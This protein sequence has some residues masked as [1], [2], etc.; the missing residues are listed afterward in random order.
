MKMN[1]KFYVLLLP[2]FFFACST[3]PYQKNE[4]MTRQA[5]DGAV[6]YGSIAGGGAAG[7][8]A[9]KQIGGSTEAGIAGAVVGTGLTY[10]V[11]KFYDKKQ[12][13][14]YEAGKNIGA[15]EARAEILNEKWK[16]EAVYGVK[17]SSESPTPSYRTVYVPSRTVDGVKQNGQYQTVKV[18]K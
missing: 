7:Y 5:T 6:R 8:F 15:D 3:A 13:D 1:L 2:S 14:A 18:Y 10:G 16:R 9:G 17:D 4:S 12:D 11:N